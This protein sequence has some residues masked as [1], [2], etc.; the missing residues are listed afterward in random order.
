MGNTWMWFVDAKIKC[1]TDKLR[2]VTT[3][4]HSSDK[5]EHTDKDSRVGQYV[6]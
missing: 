6:V 5:L 2:M 1:G 3:S 4:A